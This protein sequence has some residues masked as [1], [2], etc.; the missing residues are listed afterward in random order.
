[1][2]ETSSANGDRIKFLVIASD[3]PEARLAAFFAGRRAKRSNAKVALLAIIEPPEFGHWA[4]VAETMRAEAE[5]KAETLLHEFAAEVKAQS[6]EDPETLIR[7]G[8]VVDE[9]SRLIE[10][11]PLIS[12][13]VLGASAKAEGPGPLVASLAK[14]PA[15]LG[16]RPI[17][18]TV[19]P[20]A[21][22]R[23]ELRRLTG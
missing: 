12:I 23:D 16:G 7:E 17:P 1:M 19:V 2:S 8:E 21:M 15:Y 18:V 6:G 22:T 20:G 14:K 3:A 9:I 5:E 11:D 13:L 4:T 10:E